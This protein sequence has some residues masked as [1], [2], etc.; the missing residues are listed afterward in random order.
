MFT[1]STDDE[2][3]GY[4]CTLMSTGAEQW[5]NKTSFEGLAESLSKD[6]SGT[7]FYNFQGTAST[8]FT[9][10]HSG[11]KPDYQSAFIVM[12]LDQNGNASEAGYL[13][14]S[15]D[16][17]ADR[18]K[19]WGVVGYFSGWGNKEKD[20]KMTLEGEW[21]VARNVYIGKKYDDYSDG[22]S[23]PTDFKFRQGNDWNNDDYGSKNRETVY[24]DREYPLGRE[25]VTVHQ[26]GYY[27]IYL[28]KYFNR[29]KITET[30]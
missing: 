28:S 3:Y 6:M 8:H 4:Y 12:T 29:Y 13:I 24:P 20:V 21:L 16:P 27:D 23:K 2:S 7:G 15:F 9:H 10:R 5:L 1:I 18:L 11:D 14:V 25:N 26:A 30:K 22:G 19:D 17:G